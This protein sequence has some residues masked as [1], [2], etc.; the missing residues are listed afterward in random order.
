[1]KISDNDIVIGGWGELCERL[2]DNSWKDR[3]GIFRQDY[4][5]RGVSV[6]EYQLK[7]RFLRNCGEKGNLEYHLLRNFKKYAMVETTEALTSDWRL[8]TIGQHHGL[9]T[10]LM[11]WTYSPFVA[12]H[13]ATAN[14]EKYDRDGAIWMVDFV[15]AKELLPDSLRDKLLQAGANSFTIEMLEE[16]MPK[17]SDFKALSDTNGTL[18][19]EPPSIVDRIVNQYAFL[20]CISGATQIRMDGFVEYADS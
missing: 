7:N 18:F 11:D 1:M 14:L 4:A 19:F 5:F 9:P 16:A 3:M 17:L 2:Y 12:V 15:K 10:R 20:P 6:K 13:F 8:L